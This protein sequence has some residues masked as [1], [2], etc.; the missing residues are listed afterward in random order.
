VKLLRARAAHALEGGEY[1]D[2]DDASFVCKVLGFKLVEVHFVPRLKDVGYGHFQPL[3]ELV[4]Y[5]SS[6]FDIG[7]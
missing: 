6:C 7:T 2:D 5:D 4:C 1:D 3:H